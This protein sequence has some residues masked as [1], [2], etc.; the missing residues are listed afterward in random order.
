MAA[1]PSTEELLKKLDEQ[2]KAYLDTFKLVHEALSHNVAAN[3]P[4]SPV[5]PSKRRRRST[6]DVEA[7][8]PERKISST[9]TFPSSVVTGDSDESDEDDEL[10]VQTPLPSYKFD[11]ENL[12]DHLK[13][14]NFNESGKKI[15]ETVIENGRLLNPMLFPEYSPNDRSH[16]SHYSVFDV[17]AD[18]APLSRYDVVKAGTTSIDSAIWQVIQVGRV[19]TDQKFERLMFG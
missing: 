19:Q 4:T 9:A 5:A 18:G 12:R 2:H 15:L 8:K 6:L 3:R 16:N 13:H 11:H 10:Y 1:G 14:H 7:E 17:G